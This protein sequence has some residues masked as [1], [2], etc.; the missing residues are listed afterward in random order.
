MGDERKR[1]RGP[2]QYRI[3]VL[4]RALRVLDVMSG[5]AGA[6]GPSELSR[7]LSFHKSTIHRVLKVLQDHHLVRRNSRG[8][9]DLGFRLFEL[10]SRSIERFPLPQR[11]EPYLNQ[12]LSDTGETAEL[13]VLQNTRMISVAI[14]EA[15]WISRSVGQRAD[16]HVT[17]AGKV[18]LAFLPLAAQDDLL[19]QMTRETRN[20]VLCSRALKA[21]LAS[22]RSQ[23]FSVSDQEVEEGVR[24]VAAPIVDGK[25]RV[26]ASI[27]VVG[28]AFRI[29]SGR[30][31]ELVRMVRAMATRLSAELGWQAEIAS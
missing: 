20:T 3:Q 8:Q 2:G 26:I 16:L 23:G 9:Y 17:A 30:V 28:P 24:S 18:F 29:T 14:A 27:G 4:D 11:A 31:P 21:E 22:I 10:G 5:S 1:P 13:C 19:G 6:M 7:A 15:P 25:G 12:L